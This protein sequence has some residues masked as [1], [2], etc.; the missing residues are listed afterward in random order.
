M[1]KILVV[2]AGIA[3]LSVSRFLREHGFDVTVFEKAPLLRT[4]GAGLML[5]I[6]AVKILD[7]LGLLG[8]LVARSQVLDGF[9]M[10]DVA[11]QKISRNNARYME[12]Q[13]GFQTLAVHRQVLH[14]VLSQGLLGQ[15]IQ[16][17]RRIESLEQDSAGV[18]V[19]CSQGLRSRYDLV[20]AADGVYSSMR[21]LLN[22]SSHLR[23]AGYTCWRF[24]IPVPESV[25]MNL[26]Y[27]YWGQGKRFG[28]VPLGDD[29]LY[30][31]ATINAMKNDAKWASISVTEFKSLFCDL[32][33]LVPDVLA[34]LVDADCMIHDDLYD[35]REICFQ[36]GRV[37]FVGDAAHAMTPNM[38]QGA[39]MA[40][41]DAAVIAQC[42]SALDSVSDALQQYHQR[43]MGRVKKM[44]DQSYSFGKIA[45]WHSPFLMGARNVIMRCMPEQSLDKRMCKMLLEF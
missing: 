3:G 28:I 14:E 26:G 18:W 13:S 19:T 43:R 34:A 38:G 22:I 27:E 16:F 30:A 39:A 20:I 36:H 23:Y 17:N 32:Q 31:Y 35:Q 11:G 44:R 12:T 33:G 41:E 37:A 7:Q 6:N 9:V 24:V 45:Q 5:G 40:L 1:K 15:V 29:L 4:G 2:G 42:L 8:A 10:A 21:S 25:E